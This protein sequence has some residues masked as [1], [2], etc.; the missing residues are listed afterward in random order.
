MCGIAG[1]YNIEPAPPPSFEELGRMIGAIRHRGPDGA[2]LYR[3]A[4]V[5][6][7][8]ARLAIVD[9]EGGKQPLASLSGRTWITYNGEIYN[10]V[11]LRAELS[12]QGFGFR[13][14]SDT[15][16]LAVAWE[17]WGERCLG[18]LEGQFAFALWDVRRKRLV[19]ARDRFGV[20][21]LHVVRAGRRLAFASEIKALLQLPEVPRAID[22]AG[23]AE[24]FTFWGPIAPRTA[25][26]G[27]SEI[28]P[29][30]VAVV[31]PGGEIRERAFW[32][33]SFPERGASPGRPPSIAESEAALEEALARATALRLFRSDVPVGCYLSGGLDS[34]VIAALAR[35]A[36]A[37]PLRTFSIR[38][39]DPDLDE[40]PFQRAMAE[41]L[42]TE[43]EEIAVSRADVARCF[44]QVVAHVERPILR[45]GPAPLFL[46]SRAVHEAGI[47]VVLTGE[48]ADEVLG[49]YDLFREAKVRAFI[50]RHP[51]SRSRALLLD[52]L[53]PWM[54]RAPREARQ[55]AAR[56]FTR[57]LDP[58][59][60][61][62]SHLPRF[63]SAAA[64][65]RLFSP[66]VHEG[67]AGRDVL[68]DRLADLPEAY[69][70]WGPLARAQYLEMHTLLSGYL[71]AAQGDRPSL[72]HAVEGRFPFLDRGVVDLAARMPEGHKLRVL[73]EKL[74][75]KRIAARLVPRAILDRPK[76]PYRSPGA[77]AFLGP[78]EPAYVADLLSDRSLGEAGLFDLDG[79]RRLVAK[80]R[81]G[82][83]RA[84][85]NA[86][87]MAFLGVLSAQILW[88]ELCRRPPPAA[89]RPEGIE[90]VD[91]VS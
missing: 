9:R 87:E 80:C 56:F 62:F 28:R 46:L 49:G 45:A 41:R 26:A 67:I 75:L 14:R 66:A 57:D 44:P 43:H 50:A 27:I 36:H 7:A 76:Q 86:D 77:A 6:L 82:G 63:R 91:R 90:I 58:G 23:L 35:R 22:P 12:A 89:P 1:L 64:L 34:S 81:A 10:H 4:H 37:G 73:E 74:V 5:G 55:M 29:G 16:V 15:E 54:A 3:D 2:G 39:E 21:P 68:A 78:E 53:Y 17:A 8:H 85:G 25:F 51:G 69:D 30:H 40:G 32:T 11:E 38:F 70:R 59:A 47:K 48:G 72:A 13:T 19:L 79:V 88:H 52:R 83:G 65:Q 18:K 31:E 71:L 20:R 33:P 60:P 24:V 42:G 84:L 61:G